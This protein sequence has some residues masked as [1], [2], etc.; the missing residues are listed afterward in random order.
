MKLFIGF[1]LGLLVG[2]GGICLFFYLGAANLMLRERPS[3]VGLEET[4]QRI[5]KA[6]EAEGWKVQAVKKLDESIKKNGG[7]EVLPVRLIEVCNGKHA[8]RMMRDDDAR[9]VSVFMPCTISVYTK[10]DG[11][12]YV[13]SMNANL[14]GRLFGGTVSDVMAGHVSDAQER[15]IGAIARK[16]AATP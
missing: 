4:V 3:P 12:T 6:A 9:R 5:T 14:L 16:A 10:R 7:G 1:V 8:G 13:S 2:A 11:T 15:F